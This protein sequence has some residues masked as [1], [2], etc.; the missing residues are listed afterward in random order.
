MNCCH[1]NFD[2]FFL[3]QLAACGTKGFQKPQKSLDVVFTGTKSIV[4]PPQ[5]YEVILDKEKKKPPVSAFRGT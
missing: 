4:L 1:E 5:F 3:N 2:F